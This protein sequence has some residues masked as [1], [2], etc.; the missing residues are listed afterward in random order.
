[1]LDHLQEAS[2][3][4][5]LN[6]GQYGGCLRHCTHASTEYLHHFSRIFYFPYAHAVNLPRGPIKLGTGSEILISVS[7]DVWSVTV[8]CTLKV[9]RLGAIDEVHR[10]IRVSESDVRN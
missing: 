6:R 7:S 1:M 2:V 10:L 8:T 5:A 4:A 9:T 3:L